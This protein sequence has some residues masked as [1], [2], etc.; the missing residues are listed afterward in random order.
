LSLLALAAEE[1]RAHH[2]HQAVEGEEPPD[3][4]AVEDV[5]DSGEAGVNQAGKEVVKPPNEPGPEQDFLQHEI[6]PFMLFEAV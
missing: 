6:S 1:A 4:K 2:G 3:G 5:V